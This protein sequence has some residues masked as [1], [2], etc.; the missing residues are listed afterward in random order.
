MVEKCPLILNIIL[1]STFLIVGIFTE[2]GLH[3]NASPTFVIDENAIAKIT[4]FFSV[5]GF[6]YY[7]FITYLHS[8]KALLGTKECM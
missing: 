1:F 4:V 8:V 7:L 2:P 6:H 5:P 3:W